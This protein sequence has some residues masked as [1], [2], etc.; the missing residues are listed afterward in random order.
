MTFVLHLNKIR[1]CFE[2]SN[3]QI[4]NSTSFVTQILKNGLLFFL[5]FF[6]IK[7]LNFISL[8]VKMIL[9]LFKLI[10]N[11]SN[12]CFFKKEKSKSNIRNELKSA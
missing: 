11:F 5:R 1:K 3:I 12:R 6:Q 9:I 4:N 10:L 8:L 2:L 7:L